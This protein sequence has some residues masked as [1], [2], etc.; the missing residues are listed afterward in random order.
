MKP[1]KVSGFG[2]FSP[3]PTVNEICPVVSDEKPLL[4]RSVWEELE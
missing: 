2:G 3:D 4:T 1:D